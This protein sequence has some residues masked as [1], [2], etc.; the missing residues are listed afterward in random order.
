MSLA[1]LCC[2]LRLF[3]LITIF[4][5]HSLAQV[6]IPKYLDCPAPSTNATE[7][8]KFRDNIARLVATL[9]SS[10]AA[11]GGFASLSRG[12]GGDQAFIRGL[13]RGD[14][15]MGD[16]QTC[17]QAAG[18]ELYRNCT[19]SRRA[20]IWYEQCFVFFAD[21]N[22]T[23]AYEESYRQE[24]HNVNSVSNEATFERTYGEL[25]SS[26]AARVVNGTPEASSAAPLFATGHAVFD[27][28]ALNGTMYGL[29]QCT[30]DRTAAECGQC[31]KGSVP[32]APKCCYGHQGKV[33]LGY[34]CY[35]R[36]EVYTYYDLAL[37]ARQPPLLAPA[38]S[39]PPSIVRVT[40]KGKSEL[41][42]SWLFFSSLIDEHLS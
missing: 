5:S 18:E 21:T 11:T 7:D 23:T 4:A 29:A 42:Q 26:L 37:D 6:F 22:A 32:R 35:L 40:G 34:N 20:A 16:C 25:M 3:F 17:L 19:T 2:R 24:L 33:V 9:P 14:T 36:V 12:N 28:N 1:T 31:L 30:R 10:A 39:P 15:K 27:R 8:S 38:P 41:S 13:C